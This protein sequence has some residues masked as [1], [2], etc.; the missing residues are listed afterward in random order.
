[1]LSTMIEKTNDLSLRFCLGCS[2]LRGAAMGLLTRLVQDLAA[3][4]RGQ[5]GETSML[6][7]VALVVAILLA[8][9]GLIFAALQALGADVAGKIRN[10][11]WGG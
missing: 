4:Q 7:R 6:M 10:P 11:G 2:R 3:D 8:I 1:M 9:G 5:S